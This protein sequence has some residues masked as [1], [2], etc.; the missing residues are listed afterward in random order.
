MY[1]N[2]FIYIKNTKICQKVKKILH[3]DN[4]KESFTH[5]IELAR[6]FIQHW[7]VR[8]VTYVWK[9]S[10]RKVGLLQDSDAAM[11]HSEEASNAISCRTHFDALLPLT[12]NDA[13]LLR[14]WPQQRIMQI[15]G[16]GSDLCGQADAISKPRSGCDL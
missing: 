13:S 1:L 8:I 12:P 14:Y 11:T 15:E 6:S 7:I 4:E 2:Y 3:Q 10:L 5:S 16:V 9:V